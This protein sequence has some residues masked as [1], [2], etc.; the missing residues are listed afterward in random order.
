MRAMGRHVDIGKRFGVGPSVVGAIKRGESWRHAI[1]AHTNTT[2]VA[3]LRVTA[4]LPATNAVA[5]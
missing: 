2:E 1:T 4:K 5:A 3:T